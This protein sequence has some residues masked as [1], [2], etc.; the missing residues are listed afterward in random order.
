MKIT[1]SQLRR[2]IKES[3]FSPEAAMAAAEERIDPDLK[4]KAMQL[5]QS[6]NPED[7]ELGYQLLDTA[8]GYASPYEGTRETAKIYQEQPEGFVNDVVEQVLSSVGLDEKKRKEIR[9]DMKIQLIDIIGSEHSF[10]MGYDTSFQ[11]PRDEIDTHLLDDIKFEIQSQGGIDRVIQNTAAYKD[12]ASK[13]TLDW[14]NNRTDEIEYALPGLLTNI[15]IP[16]AEGEIDAS[17]EGILDELIDDGII[18]TLGDGRFL[19][20]ASNFN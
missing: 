10:G 5:V 11:D 17:R 7:V 12:Y 16:A 15:L 2:L 8:S 14:K 4:Q 3:Y 6:N 20:V 18:T 1:R 19:A 9:E 13:F